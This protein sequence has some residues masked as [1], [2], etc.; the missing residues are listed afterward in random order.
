MCADKVCD[1]VSDAVLD[2]CIK[3]DE[4][5]RVACE[6]CTKTGMIMIFGEITTSATVNYEAVIRETL[7]EIGYDDPAKGMDYRTVNVI[8]A[9]E[10]QS[11]D[12][13]QCVDAT[14]IEEIGAGDQGIMFGYAS[15]ETD[16]FMPYS[17]KLMQNHIL[18]I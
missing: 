13:A 1:Q 14:K 8:V 12:I 4:T 16:V 9:V 7:R 10:E 5:S 18:L 3:D 11:P 17:I 2:A 15:N 6:C